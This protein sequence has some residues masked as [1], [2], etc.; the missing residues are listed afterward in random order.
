MSYKYLS[1]LK[2]SIH[3][4]DLQK[5]L[6]LIREKNNRVEYSL[7]ETKDQNDFLKEE[8]LRLTRVKKY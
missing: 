8:P 5:D 2:N 4:A 1:V 7:V 6:C 3:D